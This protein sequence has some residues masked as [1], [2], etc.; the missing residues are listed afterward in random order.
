[1][2]GGSLWRGWL[3]HAIDRWGPPPFE[4]AA[5]TCGLLRS[6]GGAHR[7]GR[8]ARCPTARPSRSRSA[9]ARAGGRRC[10]R[11]PGAHHA[12]AAHLARTVARPRGNLSPGDAPPLH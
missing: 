1:M 2:A 4:F 3:G 11:R 9:P 7:R 5:G 10:H 12:R 8:V 6:P